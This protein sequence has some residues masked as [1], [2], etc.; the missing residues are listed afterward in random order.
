M[1]VT[2]RRGRPRRNVQPQVEEIVTPV[3]SQVN[4]PPL[5]TL[6][7]VIKLID[8]E[9]KERQSDFAKLMDMFTQFVNNHPAPSVP[10]QSVQSTDPPNDQIV[11]VHEPP[12]SLSSVHVTYDPD[13]ANPPTP[14][15]RV[16]VQ[17]ARSGVESLSDGDRTSKLHFKPTVK[18]PSFKGGTDEEVIAYIGHL[19]K[20]HNSSLLSEPE[21]LVA[22][23]HNLLGDADH[24][25]RTNGRSHTTYGE[26]RSDFLGSMLSSNYK[27]TVEAKLRN[28]L[29][30]ATESFG[31][32]CRSIWRQFRDVRPDI[33]EEEVVTIL[34]KNANPLLKTRMKYTGRLTSVNELVTVG[35]DAEA[36]IQNDRE[37]HIRMQPPSMPP[38]P[39]H[40]PPPLFMQTPER[41]R[42]RAR[43]CY[44]CGSTAHIK[45][46]CPQVLDR[47]PPSAHPETCERCGA[48]GHAARACR[49]RA[50]RAP[51]QP[52]SK[53]N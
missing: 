51:S 9:R 36:D 24:W 25:H 14:A 52:D 42:P 27:F 4:D 40:H 34:L 26:F 31:P 13:M 50:P 29:Q 41:G 49:A 46:D 1:P 8:G 43:E 30:G 22:I 18:F 19:D 15:P 53:L 20:L 47:R 28:Q 33:S 5:P 2:T 16:S 23:G 6:H 44:K 7:D 21:F 38:P 35:K 17:P 10:N 32:F 39:V 11:V 37:Y 3:V 45:R 12:G 48:Q